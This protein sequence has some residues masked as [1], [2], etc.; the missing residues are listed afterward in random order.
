MR[1]GQVGDKS[2]EMTVRVGAHV[3]IPAV[4]VLLCDGKQVGGMEG[5]LGVITNF[6][7]FK[8]YRGV[9]HSEIF[10]EKIIELAKQRKI[11]QIWTTPARDPRMKKA[12]ERCGFNEGEDETYSIKL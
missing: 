2:I 3:D 11:E 1:A 12:L 10:L 9:K 6:E 8:E 4:Y 7:I 5:S